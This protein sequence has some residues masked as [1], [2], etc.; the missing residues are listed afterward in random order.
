MAYLTPGRAENL[1][2]TQLRRGP[3]VVGCLAS[4][5]TALP[6][7]VSFCSLKRSFV[8]ALI[9]LYSLMAPSVACFWR[10]LRGRLYPL[11]RRFYA[12]EGH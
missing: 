4:A 6:T 1:G 2:I 3:N 5:T 10:L 8:V 12:A 9:V 7:Q 11:V